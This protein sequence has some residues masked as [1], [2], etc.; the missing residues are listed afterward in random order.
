MIRPVAFMIA[1][2]GNL[3]RM[4]MPILQVSIPAFIPT[5]KSGFAHIPTVGSLYAQIPTVHTLSAQFLPVLS[6]TFSRL[7]ILGVQLSVRPD[8]QGILEI[9]GTNAVC[10]LHTTT[11]GLFYCLIKGNSPMTGSC[12]HVYQSTTVHD[13][14]TI[15]VDSMSVLILSISVKTFSCI[16][17][18]WR[19]LFPCVSRM[20]P[21]TNV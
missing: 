19:L 9:Q 12:S 6:Y 17:K 16:S 8:P 15:S 1:F 11:G 7:L 21:H 4:T 13:L 5:V 3:C 20:R 14:Q 10:F 18:C 2:V